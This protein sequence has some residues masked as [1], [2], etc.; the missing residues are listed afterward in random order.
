VGKD[1]PVFGEEEY[2]EMQDEY[3]V[4]AKSVVVLL[5]IQH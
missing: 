2:L 4:K 3:L 5:S 1:I